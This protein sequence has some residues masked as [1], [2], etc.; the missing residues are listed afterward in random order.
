MPHAWCGNSL[1]HKGMGYIG[2]ILALFTIGMGTRII[3]SYENQFLAG[4]I[5]ASLVIL[6]VIAFIMIVD[7]IRYNKKEDIDA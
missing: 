6:A 5:L 2:T 1:I 4:F 7:K 3:S